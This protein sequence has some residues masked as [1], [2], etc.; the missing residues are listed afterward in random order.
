MRTR[1][2][3][4]WCNTPSIGMVKFGTFSDGYSQ[5]LNEF[6]IASGKICI[7]RNPMYDAPA[8]VISCEWGGTGIE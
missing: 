6:R 3:N 5:C 1:R 4:Q 7:C 8:V 2:R